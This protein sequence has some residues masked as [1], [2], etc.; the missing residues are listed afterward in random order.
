MLGMLSMLERELVLPPTS[1]NSPLPPSSL[2]LLLFLLFLLFL[3]LVLFVEW[4]I[5][6][7]GPPGAPAAVLLPP[8]ACIADIIMSE[9]WS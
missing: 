4:F 7:Q 5:C 3:L 1:S 9:E 2:L 8:C 6:E